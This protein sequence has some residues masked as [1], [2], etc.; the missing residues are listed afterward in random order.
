MYG[1]NGLV[2]CPSGMGRVD[3][4]KKAVSVSQE[5]YREKT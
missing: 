3:I 1:E 5:S 2:I 4:I